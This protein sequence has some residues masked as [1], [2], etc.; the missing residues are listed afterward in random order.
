M[1][2]Y[3]NVFVFSWNWES[4]TGLNPSQCKTTTHW[5]YL[6]ITRAAGVARASATTV[7]ISS[8]SINP[9]PLEY[10]SI[11]PTGTQ[12]NEIFFND[13]FSLQK[14][15]LKNLSAKCLPFCSDLNIFNPL[16]PSDTIWRHRSGSTLAQVMAN[17]DLSSVRSNDIHVRYLNYR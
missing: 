8:H 13:N 6:V 5:F 9:V 4:A 15:Y 16:W 2:I 7:G 17:V 12:L 11:R 14:M 3:K 1:M 10:L